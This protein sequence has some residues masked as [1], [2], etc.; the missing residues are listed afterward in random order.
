MWNERLQET[1]KPVES[2]MVLP[3]GSV[4]TVE[5]SPSVR[6]GENGPEPI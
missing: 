1:A 5:G 3:D 2:N 4:P 6:T